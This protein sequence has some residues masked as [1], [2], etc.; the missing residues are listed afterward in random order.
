MANWVE[1]QSRQSLGGRVK[2][3]VRRTRCTWNTGKALG[4]VDSEGVRK[5][6]GEYFRVPSINSPRSTIRAVETIKLRERISSVIQG[7]KS[8][9]GHSRTEAC[10]VNY[11]PPNVTQAQ[12]ETEGSFCADT[13]I[14]KNEQNICLVFVI[15]HVSPGGD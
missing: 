10:K 5:L 11:L 15:L 2:R 6:L 12:P 14:A 3:M 8:R 13:E 9:V 1:Q 4:V 7:S